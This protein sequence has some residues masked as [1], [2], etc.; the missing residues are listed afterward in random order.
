[1]SE[2]SKETQVVEN[3]QEES[4][5]ETSTEEPL[6]H[7]DVADKEQQGHIDDILA[8]FQSEQDEVK[9]SEEDPQEPEEDFTKTPEDEEEQTEEPDRFQE[10]QDEIASLK[11]QLAKAQE[12]EE[13]VE[14]PSDTEEP[15]KDLETLEF[16]EDDVEFE[17][18]LNSREEF[19]NFVSR[20]VDAVEQSVLQN[21][22]DVVSK[23]VERQT[24]QQEVISSWRSE[25]QDLIDEKPKFTG[26]VANQV[27]SEHPDWSLEQQLQETA[28]RVRKELDL[29]KEAT[30]LE[31]ER[32]SKES[33]SKTKTARK[34]RGSRGGANPDT[35]NE[36]QKQIDEILR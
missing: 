30:K 36:Q 14:E 2:E 4:E 12:K 28:K 34:P 13:E 11:E 5:V 23:T 29:D 15:K 25:N 9:Q 10:L 32:K 35:R 3:G 8:G 7:E 20:L 6:R 16:F 27:Q 26:W 17:Q 22:P 18:A 21:I 24:T 31:K 19:N 33:S 1:M